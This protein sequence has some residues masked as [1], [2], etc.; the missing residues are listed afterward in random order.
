MTADSIIEKLNAGAKPTDLLRSILSDHPKYTNHDLPGSFAAISH[1][2]TFSVSFNRFG[3]GTGRREG[4][5]GAIPT[6]SL[7]P[8]CSAAF[9]S[10]TTPTLLFSQTKKIRMTATA[11]QA[12][13][14]TAP[15]GCAGPQID[16]CLSPERSLTLGR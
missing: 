12:P 5:R 2:L 9:F 11:N 4:G 8:F 14:R 7:K 3:I 13:Q 6:T 16:A 15:G 10:P 1:A